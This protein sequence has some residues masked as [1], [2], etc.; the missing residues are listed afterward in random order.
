[1]RDRAETAERIGAP[2]ME[3][4]AAPI[5]HAVAGLVNQLVARIPCR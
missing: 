2:T 5:A 1:M 4:A 3:S